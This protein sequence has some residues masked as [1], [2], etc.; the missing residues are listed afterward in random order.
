MTAAP[1]STP[2]CML[3]SGPSGK[4]PAAE[5]SLLAYPTLYPHPLQSRGF[6]SLPFP[7]LSFLH[8]PDLSAMGSLGPL[9]LSSPLS[10]FSSSLA[11][12]HH[13]LFLLSWPRPVCW[14]CSAHSFSSQLWILPD[15]C[16]CP[17]P[18]ICNKILPLNCTL[19]QSL[20]SFSFSE[21]HVWFLRRRITGL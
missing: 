18:R 2:K 1:I 12:P 21:H 10:V 5:S 7:Q 20:S 6:P 13:C 17:F 15:A 11:L 9:A 19:E 8:N 16:G 3:A 4:V 14:P